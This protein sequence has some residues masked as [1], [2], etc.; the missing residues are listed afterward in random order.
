MRFSFED[1][2]TNTKII[3]YSLRGSKTSKLLTA[4]DIL[5]K[6]DTR[7]LLKPTF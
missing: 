4:K 3:G 5:I 1:R 2:T 7:L 6:K